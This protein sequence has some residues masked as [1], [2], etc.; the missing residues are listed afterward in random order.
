MG[1]MRAIQ[2]GE[3]LTTEQ[4]WLQEYSTRDVLLPNGVTLDETLF[5]DDALYPD[6]TVKTGTVIS[7]DPAT[8][9]KFGPANAAHPEIYVLWRTI[10]FERD[11]ELAE[12]VRGG[13]TLVIEKFMPPMSAAIKAALRERNFQF[14]PYSNGVD[15]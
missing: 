3:T 4:R 14:M 9:E 8:M 7:R 2:L 6:G 15:E 11:G 10:N 13:P 12:A 1:K 5:T